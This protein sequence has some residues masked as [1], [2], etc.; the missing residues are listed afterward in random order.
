MSLAVVEEEVHRFL[1]DPT[2]EVLCIKGNADITARAEQPDEGI[3]EQPLFRSQ[4][5]AC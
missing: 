3:H 5:S 2:S 1:S 4:I